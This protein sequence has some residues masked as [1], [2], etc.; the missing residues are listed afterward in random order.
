M[1][2]RRF[3]Q[4]ARGILLLCVILP[5]LEV[6][7]QHRARGAEPSSVQFP[8]LQKILVPQNAP[9]IWP[10]A[11]WKPIQRTKLEALLAKIRR[12]PSADPAGIIRQATYSAVF[13]GTSFQHGRFSL[14]LEGAEQATR[15]ISLEPLNLRITD[16]SWENHQRA[17]WGTAPDL[18]MILLTEKQQDTLSGSWSLLGKRRLGGVVFE[19]HV[20]AAVRTQFLLTLPRHLRLRSNCGIVTVDSE[21]NPNS[22]RIWRVEL[23]G[24]TR[25]RLTVDSEES[26][27]IPQPLVLLEDSVTNLV[28]LPDQF[29]ISSDLSLEILEAP[30]Q[31]LE[32]QVDPD[33]RIHSVTSGNDVSIPLLESTIDGNRRFV[34]KFDPPIEGSD[35]L[36][37][38]HASAP[39]EL[40]RQTRL[41]RIRVVGAVQGRTLLN[42]AVREPLL[43]KKFTAPPEYRQMDPDRGGDAI[44]L[45]Y[46]GDRGEVTAVVGWPQAE[47]GCRVHSRLIPAPEQ[48]QLRSRMLWECRS[49][50]RFSLRCELPRGWEI[51]SVQ[52]N[53]QNGPGAIPVESWQIVP[54]EGGTRHL[55][56]YLDE[57]LVKMRP[58]MTE[59]QAIRPVPAQQ[60]TTSIPTLLP[61][62][63]ED[64]EVLLSVETKQ[65]AQPVLS[66]GT[67]YAPIDAANLPAAWKQLQFTDEFSTG[68]SGST[69]YL[70]SAANQSTG[71]LHFQS[72]ETEV[73]VAAEVSCDITS[74]RASEIFQLRFQAAVTDLPRVH[75]F[76]T[77]PG[78]AINW[79]L[80]GAEVKSL[81]ARKLPTA[82]HSLMNLPPSGELWE[83]ELPSR[84][85]ANFQL[86]GHRIRPF[87]A[88]GDVGLVFVPR[89]QT[90]RGELTVSL[91]NNVSPR[92]ESRRLLADASFSPEGQTHKSFR[93][94]YSN[95]D[96]NLRVA[97]QREETFL[98]PAV[99]ASVM[100]RSQ[101]SLTADGD[102]FHQASY[103]LSAFPDSVEFR[104]KM[105]SDARLISVSQGQTP[106][107]P[108]LDGDYFLLGPVRGGRAESVMIAFSTPTASRLGWK[109]RRL[110]LPHVEVPV[111]RFNW[112]LDLPPGIRPHVSSAEAFVVSNSESDHW[113][114]RIFGPLRRDEDRSGISEDVMAKDRLVV[115]NEQEVAT[116]ATPPGWRVWN[117]SFTTAPE[118][119]DVVLWDES[120]SKMLSFALLILCLCLTW[121]ARV[122]GW[123]VSRKF[124]FG[125]LLGCLAVAS[126]V[127]P[128]YTELAGGV[129]IGSLFACLLPLV[130]RLIG[131]NQTEQMIIVP[132]GSTRKAL[133]IVSS[134]LLA[135]FCGGYLSAKGQESIVTVARKPE[136]AD[137]RWQMLIPY[138]ADDPRGEKAEIVYLESAKLESLYALV[139]PRERLPEYLL[140]AAEY[141]LESTDPHFAILKARLAVEVLSTANNVEIRIPLSNASLARADACQING[142]PHP[143]LRDPQG[144]GFVVPLS[145]VHA[146]T[147]VSSAEDSQESIGTSDNDE[148]GQISR[149]DILELTLRVATAEV[150]GLRRVRVDIP[151]ISDSRLS[152]PESPGFS[153]VQL[154]M[155]PFALIDWDA[156]SVPETHSVDLGGIQ[157][158]EVN[159][160]K[161]RSAE[162]PH[163]EGVSVCLIEVTPALIR[164]HARVSY[165]VTDGPVDYVTWRLPPAVAIR[166]VEGDAVVGHQLFTDEQGDRIVL[167]ELGE[168]QETRFDLSA[169][170]VLRTRSQEQRVTF[171]VLNLLK[172]ATGDPNLRNKEIVGIAAPREY[173]LELK[174][175]DPDGVQRLGENE[176]I[177]RW[178]AETILPRTVFGVVGDAQLTA[179]IRLKAPQRSVETLFSGRI[180]SQQF[181]WEL[182]AKMN[183]QTALA[184]QHR[185][186][187]DPRLRIETV[188]VQQAG[189]ER[190]DRSIRTR[191]Q[192]VLYLK[193]GVIGEQTIRLTGTMPLKF[194]SNFSLPAVG[195][196]NA[197]LKNA[198]VD[199]CHDSDLSVTLLGSGAVS[200][201]P[202]KT[203]NELQQPGDLSIGRFKISSEIEMEQL[204]I[205][206]EENSPQVVVDSLNVL[207]LRR[208]VQK[209]TTVLLFHVKEGH[210]SS[211]TIRVPRQFENA[212]RVDD[213]QSYR[214]QKTDGGREMTFL[215]DV[216]NGETFV[217]QLTFPIDVADDGTLTLDQITPVN[218]T[219][220]E[221]FLLTLFDDDTFQP[222]GDFSGL[223][224]ESLPLDLEA[225][226][227]QDLPVE[228]QRRAYRGAAGT[229]RLHSR[230]EPVSIDRTVALMDTKISLNSA[231]ML[232][233][234]TAFFI[235]PCEDEQFVVT[236]PPQA[237]LQAALNEDQRPVTTTIQE[238]EVTVALDAAQVGQVVTLYW[239]MPRAS[240]RFSW[241]SRYSC[242]TPRPRDFVVKQ[243]TLALIPSRN[244]MM[245][246]AGGS[247]LQELT[248]EY[249]L[250]LLE[251]EFE[252]RLAQTT[253]GHTQQARLW[254][255][256]VQHQ[257][258]VAALLVRE[259]TDSSEERVTGL[260][261]RFTDLEARVTRAMLNSSESP[262]VEL[263]QSELVADSYARPLV[264][265]VKS[266][267]DGSN[268][269]SVPRVWVIEK[270]LVYALLALI[271]LTLLILLKK[272]STRFGL[273]NVDWLID[274][275]WIAW[276]FV[277]ICWWLLLAEGWIGL[278]IAAI[279]LLSRLFFRTQEANGTSEVDFVV[280]ES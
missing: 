46:Y 22:P 235:M 133:P 257:Q 214:H 55:V 243:A 187:L 206:T 1:R 71:S 11:D 242:P 182:N 207:D 42:L 272:I 221:R 113:Q 23:G 75:V 58:L 169:R 72:E 78:P 210:A 223:T 43:L 108:I 9:D 39:F 13:S 198:E 173:E 261:S 95:V 26:L 175:T 134:C 188:S 33:V 181:S 35:H 254:N 60:E 158:L 152:I 252:F 224:E 266:Q 130:G 260:N 82:R 6:V 17:I 154:R 68:D 81:K 218:A 67:S 27:K 179:R 185:L 140:S 32:F 24:R 267:L 162:L 233:G 249:A 10:R 247:H 36:L 142:I 208:G 184:F 110:P 97:A 141:E 53:V 34:V 91:D 144:D 203:D 278:I 69:Q 197:E 231:R 150:K 193:T 164:Y 73:N 146:G 216:G 273:G 101:M 143:I 211:F 120:Q 48:W 31:Q 99:I 189:A 145:G 199:L 77:Q 258:Q 106:L 246:P 88:E 276:S 41:P 3:C 232:R 163:P 25:C 196:F 70:L 226:L 186:Q 176:F 114:R 56:M 30:L 161:G 245:T 269:T 104:W 147:S 119:I 168:A 212:Y 8:G 228:P 51:V 166:S 238:Q 45:Q 248:A 112:Q 131:K 225:R 255:R 90:F 201:V 93:W 132:S 241:M 86:T 126:L 40:D 2:V 234:E 15:Y 174:S 250:Q 192:L 200:A 29:R 222:T 61:K 215:P 102:D 96:A 118:A 117:V 85:A 16:L 124:V 259:N 191:D 103:D 219:S 239:T 18:G 111:L 190:L 279:A 52:R 83:I 122:L 28:A 155:T 209:L 92:F 148:R 109:S 165:R 139:Q 172:V 270:R 63:V 14:S 264:S 57:A 275:P 195:F 121:G 19:V 236:L 54:A 137:S 138:S 202:R 177:D 217:A 76:V 157:R 204:I 94:T 153:H 156:S 277:G 136:Q 229:W 80:V 5:A 220:G 89:T 74:L 135:I 87:S 180:S 280:A 107:E 62:D 129:V 7:G 149:R 256:F 268:T 65:N 64:Y 116:F 230:E 49:G 79:E 20:S 12:S 115:R 251:S 38:I 240:H 125:W 178:S 127:P 100:L 194:P 183:V 128:P 21:P 37:H 274:R 171:P 167:I 123:N 170:F 159:W 271:A 59:I 84:I 213:P 98:L 205:Q 265:L 44:S 4:V 47:V 237:E 253:A 66:L 160:S 227:P 151:R 105:P 50:Q 244:L 262:E 263:V